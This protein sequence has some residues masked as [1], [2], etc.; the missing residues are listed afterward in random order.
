MNK[1]KFPFK[2]EL[3]CCLVTR[4]ETPNS[5]QVCN[6]QCPLN[7]C[8]EHRIISYLD[9]PTLVRDAAPKRRWQAAEWQTM[10]QIEN[11]LVL[12]KIF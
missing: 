12:M 7:T 10:H 2:Y 6:P 9:R 3:K 11:C 8:Q 4:Y 5:Y 1:M